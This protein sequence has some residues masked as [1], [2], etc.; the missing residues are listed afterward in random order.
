MSNKAHT[1]VL[2]R[3]SERYGG[4]SGHADGVDIVTDEM[5]IEVETS[6]T[7][8]DGF[9]R[10]AALS[11]TRYVAVTNKEAI[12]DALRLAAGT[13]IGVMDAHGNVLH[14]ANGAPQSE[15]ADD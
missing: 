14:A 6:A 13:G 15:K 2:R 12:S 10:L 8:A 11:G 5:R 7:L 9:A 3:I 1:A 4:V